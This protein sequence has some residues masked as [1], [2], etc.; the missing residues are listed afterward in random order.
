MLRELPGANVSASLVQQRQRERHQVE[1][2]DPLGVVGI[3]A[4]SLDAVLAEL[5]TASAHFGFAEIGQWGT[6]ITVRGST[7]NVSLG[8][9]QGFGICHREP[10]TIG[11]PARLY[12]AGIL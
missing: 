5:T 11:V 9:G 10:S 6:P 1:K 8:G 7:P 12:V 2:C 3:Q 4:V